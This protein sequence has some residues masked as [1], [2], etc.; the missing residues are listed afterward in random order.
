MVATQEDSYNLLAK[1]FPILLQ[2]V[3]DGNEELQKGL[4]PEIRA[5]AKKR[6]ISNLAN[7]IITHNLSKNLDDYPG[8]KY[9]NKFDQLKVIFPEGY[10]LKCKQA[11]S[12]RL[13][14]IPTQIMFEFMNQLQLA[15]P[16]M[17]L[18]YTNIVL[19]FQFNKTRTAVESVNLIC[20]ADKTKLHWD[21]P[22]NISTTTIPQQE[23]I[24]T[25]EFS[26]EIKRI[27]PKP[28]NIKKTKKGTVKKDEQQGKENK[29]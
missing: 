3:L 9:S 24:E 7:D 21:I 16:G 10:L 20:P 23:M 22:F 1:Y 4:P 26:P 5:K 11:K 18:P 27:T 2:S 6:S 12:N 13:S 17:P 29:S 15:F 14:F 19:T 25:Q 8:I 28:K